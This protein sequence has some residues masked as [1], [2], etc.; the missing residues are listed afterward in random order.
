MPNITQ[1][2]KLASRST[3]VT[4]SSTASIGTVVQLMAGATSSASQVWRAGIEPPLGQ[5]V[6]NWNDAGSVVVVA[7]V[8]SAC[9]PGGTVAGAAVVLGG[10]GRT[11]DRMSRPSSLHAVTTSASAAKAMRPR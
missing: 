6:S 11:G 9:S 10:G 7:A 3:I 8:P 5:A 1:C 2:T 4:A